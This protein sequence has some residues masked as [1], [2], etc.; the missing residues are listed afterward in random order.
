MD[1]KDALKATR[2]KH[3][4][5]LKLLGRWTDITEARLEDIESGRFKMTADEFKAL[6]RALSV[7]PRFI[8]EGC[9]TAPGEQMS[10][11]EV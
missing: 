7:S 8:L 10:I 6:C 4:I 1:A 3:N 9:K 2:R 5:S 11:M